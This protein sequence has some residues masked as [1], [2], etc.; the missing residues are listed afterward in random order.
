MKIVYTELK[1]KAMERNISKVQSK[2]D[3]KQIFIEQWNWDNPSVSGEFFDTRAEIQDFIVESDVLAE[4]INAQVLYFE[5]ANLTNPEKQMKPLERKI[6]VSPEM[7]N[8]I[9]NSIFV[10]SAHDF[11]YCDFVKAEKIGAAIKIKRFSINPENR[12]KLRTTQEQ[13]AKLRI[14]AAKLSPSYV[15]N[16]IEMAFSVEAITEKFYDDYIAIFQKIKKNLQKQKVEVENEKQEEKLRDFIHQILNRLMFLYFVQRRGC[17]AGDK[18]FLANFWDKYKESHGGKNNFHSAWLGAL[19][20]EAL[21]QP[22]FLYSE[23]KELGDFN[24]ILKQAPY[25]N[26]G[27]FEKSEL[28]D[29]GWQIA[30][31]FF[32]DIFNFLQGYNFT[33]EESTPLDIDIA[34]NPEMLGNIYEHLVNTEEAQEQAK[35][36]I[37]YTPKTEIGIMIERALVEFLFGK[38]SAN[39]EKL[40][41]FV[42]N[43]EEV[44]VLDKNEAR[45]VLR[46]LNEILI[47]D[48]ACGSG[49][50][51]V[52]CSQTLYSLKLTLRELLGEETVGKYQAKKE[53]IEKNL[54]GNDVKPWAANVAKLRLW[55]DLFVDAQDE[56]L[57]NQTEPL[58]PNLGFK[59]RH[60]DSLLQEL[61]GEIIP[62]RKIGKLFAS[63]RADLK[64]LIA[65]K[66]FVYEKGTVEDFKQTLY[67]EKN[68][69]R[70]VLSMEKIKLQQKLQQ[71]NFESRKQTESLFGDKPKIQPSLFM[72]EIEETKTATVSVDRLQEYLIKHEPPM[73]WDLAFA[74][75]FAMKNGFDIVIANPPLCSAGTNLRPQWH[76]SKKRIQK[77]T[78]CANKN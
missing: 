11:N 30:D 75:V 48:P 52:V 32:E 20:F 19:F 72:R 6:I 29:I 16:Q 34:I 62:L 24:S 71:L 39:K 38:T 66:R 21:N 49:H 3:L 63:R 78:N 4:I 64:N 10:F 73:L 58:L 7:K 70:Q 1:N 15:K 9:T 59:I 17:F 65:K 28:D 2:E 60:G 77:Q 22:S 67:L 44:A 41:Q 14:E 18:D 36:G 25:L 69:L 53:I 74:E 54:Y 51:L 40:Y 12:N 27:L 5:L 42:F 35:A 57:Q 46:E 37:F 76:L 45:E 47:L 55:L 31:D 33:I 26:G 50:Y 13:L 43:P 8:K 23:K 68:L 56:F 61:A